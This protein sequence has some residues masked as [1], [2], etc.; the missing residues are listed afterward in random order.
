MKEVL[1]D[2]VAANAWIPTHILADCCGLCVHSY[3]YLFHTRTSSLPDPQY[4]LDILDIRHYGS[5]SRGRIR[6]SYEP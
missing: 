5:S 6:Y 2:Q 4:Y 1:T 3:S